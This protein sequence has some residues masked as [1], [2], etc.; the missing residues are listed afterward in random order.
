M[1]AISTCWSNKTKQKYCSQNHCVLLNGAVLIHIWAFLDFDQA[2]LI[3][4]SKTGK[5]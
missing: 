2:C 5:L 4:A 1:A 3:D